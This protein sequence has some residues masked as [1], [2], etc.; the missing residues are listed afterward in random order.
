MIEVLY[1]IIGQTVVRAVGEAVQDLARNVDAR[2][3]T[4]LTPAAAA[5][6]IK[7]RIS[8][9]SDAEMTLRDALPF[10]V[11][12]VFLIHRE[13]GLLLQHLS[14]DQAAA[15]DSD[16]VSGMLTAIRDFVRDAFGRGQEGQL[17]SIQYGDRRILIEAAQLVY[18]AVVVAGVEP[19]G[20][21]AEMRETVIGIDNRFRPVLR[22]YGGDA[23]L[24]AG[25]RE[26]MEPLLTSG[27]EPPAP[28]LTR[29][30]KR[31]L[32]GLFA[33]LALCLLL[34]CGG[35]IWLARA[36]TTQPTPLV[37]VITATP[38]VTPTA[39]STATSTPTPTP[40]FTPT[41]TPTATATRTPTGTAT[42]TRSATPTPTPPLA[43]VSQ[44]IRLNLRAGPGLDQDVLTVVGPGTRFA[45]LERSSNGLWW[46]VCCAPDGRDGWVWAQFLTPV[47]IPGR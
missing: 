37:M 41:A 19:A 40:T 13:T 21:R 12:E 25:A 4:T 44:S 3:R 35:S 32:G 10:E 24:V 39:T 16:L 7:A 2:V 36:V 15:Q 30:Q 23:T 26:S 47:A 29:T 27:R 45:L 9:V 20:Y 11:E 46:H 43:A 22:P 34:A 38:T 1:P 31:I 28:P 17:D 14:Q 42:P 5:R 33:V 18:L 8:G 6:R